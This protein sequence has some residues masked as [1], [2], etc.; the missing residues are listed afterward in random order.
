MTTDNQVET[1][2]KDMGF[3]WSANGSGINLVPFCPTCH[4]AV[5]KY[6]VEVPDQ[7]MD[8]LHGRTSV[9]TGEIIVTIDCHGKTFKRSNFRGEL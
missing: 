8:T 5:S 7:K 3:S 6:S 2:V 9:P 4:R 1:I